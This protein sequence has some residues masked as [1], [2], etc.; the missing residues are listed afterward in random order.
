MAAIAPSY[1]KTTGFDYPGQPFQNRH[2]IALKLKYQVRLQSA[3]LVLVIV[4]LFIEKVSQA[5]L[6]IFG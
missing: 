1:A 6:K 2:A 4:F 3:V 5:A